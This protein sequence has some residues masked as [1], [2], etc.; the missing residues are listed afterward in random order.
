MIRKTA[1]FLFVVLG[2][3]FF[4]IGSGM[5]PMLGFRDEWRAARCDLIVYAEER[6]A[7]LADTRR[8][9]E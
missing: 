7:D 4:L 1:L 6:G 8:C 3:V 2:W 5:H 9:E